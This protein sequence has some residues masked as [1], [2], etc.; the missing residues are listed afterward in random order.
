[1]AKINDVCDYIILRVT[2]ERVPLT[3]TKLHNLL[4]YVQAWSLALS[5]KPMFAEKFQAWVH[6][7]VS[8]EI[9]NRFIGTKSLFS[10]MFS[11]IDNTYVSKSFNIEDL[12]LEEK[13]HID[14]VLEVYAKYAGS[15][16]EEIVKSE[17]P[18][19]T[20]REGYGPPQRCIR[21][22]DETVIKNYYQKKLKLLE[23][24]K[25]IQKE[26]R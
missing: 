6:G 21:E 10:I 25:S 8:T 11:V 4:Y 5:D 17:D 16:L 2:E 18:W 22:I 23:P 12:S 14:D 19:I 3:I 7:P 24:I 9:Y 1:M 26:S 13:R 20:T 15:Q